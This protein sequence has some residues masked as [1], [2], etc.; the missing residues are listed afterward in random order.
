MG[1]L[2]ATS[3]STWSDRPTSVAV[4]HS[5]M[6]SA[7]RRANASGSL[8]GRNGARSP[9]GETGALVVIARG[10]AG[11]TP[12]VPGVAGEGRTCSE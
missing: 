3:C 12:V 10:V 9:T 7:T 5:K 6:A 8:V 1:S 11:A 2:T 4:F